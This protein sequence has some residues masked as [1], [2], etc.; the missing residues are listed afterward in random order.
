MSKSVGPIGGDGHGEFWT[1]WQKIEGKVRADCEK[2]A[3][4]AGR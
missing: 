4:R 2:R 1:E 3:V